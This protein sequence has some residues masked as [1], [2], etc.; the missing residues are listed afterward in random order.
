MPKYGWTTLISVC[1]LS[2]CG[3]LTGPPSITASRTFYNE[4]IHDT[5]SQQ[6]LL[7]I[8]RVKNYEVPNFIDVSEADA[9]VSF[10]TGTSGGFSGIGAQPGI[11]SVSAGTIAGAV[12]AITGTFTYGDS[13]LVRYAP[14]QGYPLIQQVSSPIAPQSIVRMFNSD[15]GLADVLEFSVDRLAPG[16]EDNYVA[17]DRMVM[18]D[19][20]GAIVLASGVDPSGNGG[21]GRS[22][23][24]AARGGGDTAS[25]QNLNV[26]LHAEALHV[27]RGIAGPGCPFADQSPSVA[28]AKLWTG[29]RHLYHDSTANMITLRGDPSP[30]FFFTTRSAVGALK[31][32]EVDAIYFTS[33]EDAAQIRALNAVAPCRIN[34]NIFYFNPPPPDRTQQAVNVMWRSYIGDTLYPNVD[35]DIRDRAI[36]RDTHR[37]FIIVEESPGAPQNAYVAVNRRGI[38]YWI[39]D[40]DFVSK[41]NFALLNE[42]VTIQAVPEQKQPLTPSISVGR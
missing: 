23:A 36:Y 16:F 21:R 15:F 26:I 11:R 35:K 8:I 41:A 38:W 10:N 39:D 3:S 18:L 33:P 1:L 6:L 31:E 30:S 13:A 24:G 32:A 9:T 7:N 27:G 4:A 29:L 28:A 2:G 12:S 5:S 25:N 42:I 22:K 17:Q 37:A 34:D 40:D 14:V 19:Q 20:L